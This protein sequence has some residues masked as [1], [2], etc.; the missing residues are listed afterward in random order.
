MSNKIKII[1]L[2]D[3]TL[4]EGLDVPKVEF[5]IAARRA[6]FKRLGQA[7]AGEMELVAPSRVLQDL[8][9][10]RKLGR[11]VKKHVTS[12]LVYATSTILDREVEALIAGVSRFDILLPVSSHRTPYDLNAKIELLTSVLKSINRRYANFGVGFPNATQV[13]EEWLMR[14][15]DVAV[16]HGAQRLT[17]YDTNGSIDPFRLKPLIE[18][19]K[20]YLIANCFF[21]GIMIWDWQPRMRWQPSLLA[22]MVW[23]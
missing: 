11:F 17:I 5:D 18:R 9:W 10:V 4:R 6:I 12:G 22:P 23:M 8:Q 16:T 20:K 3:A 21:M 1:V 2:K 14:L 15:G 13:D 19:L 7:R